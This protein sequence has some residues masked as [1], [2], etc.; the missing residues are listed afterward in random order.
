METAFNPPPMTRQGRRILVLSAFVPAPLFGSGTRVFELVR[1]LARRHEVTVLTYGSDDDEGHLERLRELG[2]AVHVVAEGTRSSVRRRL[3]QLVSIA[4]PMPFHVRERYSSTMQR[5]LDTLAGQQSFDVVQLEGSQLCGFQL[6]IGPVHVLDEHN[7]EYEV[8]QRMS[9]GERT[10]PRR[11][12]SAVEYRKFRR[13][14]ERWWRRVD[15]VA[16]TSERE[17]HTVAGHA[18]A[19]VTAVVPNAVDPDHF[20]PDHGREDPGSMLFM[21]TLDYRPNVDAVEYLLEEILP[22][23]RA[24]R[25]DAA[26]TI[27]GQGEPQALERFRQPGV[28]VTG[29][30]PDVRPWL[31]RAAVAVVPVRIGGGTRLKVVEALSMEKAVVSTTLGCEGLAVTPGTHVLLADGVMDFAAAVARVLAAPEEYRRLGAAGRALVV[32]RYSWERST[33]QLEEMY[34][35]LLPSTGAA[36]E[37]V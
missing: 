3:D 20:Q 10:A 30:V 16:V 28:T 7:V 35:K 15:G 32:E 11:F 12:F 4:S 9:E 26:L 8:L 34:D 19:A 5:A 27:V 14:E 18:P 29:R 24:V 21:G 13:I 17:V 1:H 36:G 23:V 37:P 33:A 22:A 31:A 25:P 2:V 6:P